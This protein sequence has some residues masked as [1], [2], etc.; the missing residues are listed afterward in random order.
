MKSVRGKQ[1]KKVSRNKKGQLS[2]ILLIKLHFKF[3]APEMA[4]DFGSNFARLC[5]SLKVIRIEY[6]QLK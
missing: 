6:L 2:L 4:F 3:H 1:K 5:I